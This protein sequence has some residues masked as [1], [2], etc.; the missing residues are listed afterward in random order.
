MKL[1]RPI[2]L[3]G[4]LTIALTACQ[5]KTET[6]SNPIAQITPDEQ[7]DSP[8]DDIKDLA[9]SEDKISTANKNEEQ[10][11]SVERPKRVELPPPP[12]EIEEI[13]EIEEVEE[14]EAIEIAEVIDI[15]SPA[16]ADEP[17]P[18]YNFHEYKKLDAFLR[19][20]VTYS[21]KV[22]YSSIKKN[23]GEL[24][25]IIK[26]IEENAPSTSWSSK[27]KLTYWINVYNIYTIKLVAENYPTS[28]IK[29][30][31]G[32]KPWDKKFI[33]IGGKTYSL[34]NV[35]NDVIRK[36]FSEPRI[37]FALNCA[38]ASC[39]VLLNKAYTPKNLY[40]YL[41]SQTKRFLNDSGKNQFTAKEAKIS[42]IFSWYKVDFTK[43]G[44]TVIDF[45][46]KYRTEQLKSPKVSYLNYSWDLN[47]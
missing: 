29:K 18:E 46:N 17:E 21:G 10:T 9:K 41:T 31:N 14:I 45:I 4:A 37:H 13:E 42:Q 8:L 7:V 26:E 44:S 36:R 33:K 28:S 2:F 3:A 5:A 16:P 39:P 30:L 12:P 6:E 25:A 43:N 24:T 34:N 35:E 47:D 19:K 11:A 15:A 27:Q 23:I 20:Y 1:N 22:N 32:G 38:S 40:S